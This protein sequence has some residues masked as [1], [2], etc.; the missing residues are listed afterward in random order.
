[1]G[2]GEAEPGRGMDHRTAGIRTNSHVRSG[3]TLGDDHGAG[4]RNHRRLTESIRRDSGTPGV[5]GAV[6]IGLPRQK[7]PIYRDFRF[8]AGSNGSIRCIIS[9]GRTSRAWAS[10]TI[11]P[12]VGLWMPRSRRLM[13]DRSTP[14][15]TLSR[16]WETFRSLRTSFNT[17]P[18]ALSGPDDGCTCLRRDS[19][20]LQC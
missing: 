18:N 16:A 7:N 2:P 8:H 19:N 20:H 3:R 1:M 14:A 4:P 5:P 13:Y 11:I 17:A 6:S 10:V 12:N 15:I 9:E